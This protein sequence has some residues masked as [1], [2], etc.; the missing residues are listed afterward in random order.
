MNSNTSPRVAESKELA[1]KEGARYSDAALT[2]PVD[3]IEDSGGITLFA[4]LPGVSREKLGLHVASDTL[5][6]EAESDLAV[7]EGLESSHTEV[8][9]GRFRRVFTLSKELDTAAISAELKQGV[10][11][12]RI[13]KAEHAQPR[14]I[15]IQA[16]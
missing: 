10:L 16:A 15:E 13:P 2:P 9:L 12:L 14:R 8:G 7:P 6:I 11:K 3:V 4:D 1:R 5:T